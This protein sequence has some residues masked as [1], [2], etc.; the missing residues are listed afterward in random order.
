MMWEYDLENMEADAE[1]SEG[2]RNIENF[3]DSADE[4]EPQS[5]ESII[6]KV[7]S[8]LYQYTALMELAN[9]GEDV[10][11]SMSF[12]NKQFDE[13]LNI[14]ATEFGASKEQIDE[15]INKRDEIVKSYMG[16]ASKHDFVDELEPQGGEVIIDKVD[17]ILYQYTVLMKLANLGEDVDESMSFLNKKFDETLNI[18]ETEFGVSKEQI[19]EY[20]NKRDEIVKPYMGITSKKT[21]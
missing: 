16:T 8:I 11:G 21:L 12:L 14:L 7:D 19:D 15:Y 10:D 6:D 1:K 5:E 13:T 9:L 18:L 4:L 20:I 17:S 3:Q 2:E